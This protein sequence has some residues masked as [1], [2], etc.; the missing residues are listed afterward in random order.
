MAGAR[1]IRTLLASAAVLGALV[2][3]APTTS[4]AAAAPSDVGLA[5]GTLS[6]IHEVDGCVYRII[7]GNYG[8]APYAG[9]LG[10]T[11]TCLGFTVSVRSADSNGTHWTPATEV[12]GNDV[13]DV[14]GL[15]YI[16]QANGPSPGYAL[17]ARIQGPTTTVTYAYDGTTAPP[18]SDYCD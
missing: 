3:G 6:G 12:A 16:I 15:H 18:V 2:L 7:Y 14:C 11:T 5:I 10:Y 8:S 9:I 1:R 13:D 4:P 17:G